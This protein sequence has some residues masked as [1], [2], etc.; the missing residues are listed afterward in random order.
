MN[1]ARLVT[2][3]QVLLTES[4][5]GCAYER[6]VPREKVVRGEHVAEACN[7]KIC[8]LRIR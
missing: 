3:E 1:R 6:F 8:K 2:R 4:A 7:Y 5:F